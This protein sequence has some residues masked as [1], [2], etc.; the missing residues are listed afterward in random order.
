MRRPALGKSMFSNCAD[1]D[2][3]DSHAGK[4]YEVMQNGGSSGAR[5]DKVLKLIALEYYRHHFG[6]R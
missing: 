3:V 5:F 2:V 6:G 1:V 4:V